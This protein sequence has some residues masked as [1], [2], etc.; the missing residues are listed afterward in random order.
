MTRTRALALAFPIVLAS[1]I[2]SAASDD[3][4]VRYRRIRTDD[5]RLQRLLDEGMLRSATLRG[6]VQRITQ[7]DVVV[8][9]RCDGDPLLRIAGRLTFLSA[10]GGIRHLVVRLAPLRSHAQQI[11]ILAHELQHAVEVADAPAIVDSESLAREYLRIG[12]V[13]RH[14]PPPGIA[15]DTQAAIDAGQQVFD[16]LVTQMGD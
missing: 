2:P 9:V 13:N 14:A 7:S 4:D 8:Y 6:L 12:H 15:F 10:V 16:E 5:R 3:L 1:S 11:A